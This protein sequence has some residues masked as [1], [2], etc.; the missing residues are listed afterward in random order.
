MFQ[1]KPVSN[2]GRSCI[3]CLGVLIVAAAAAGFTSLWWVVWFWDCVPNGT[4]GEDNYFSLYLEDGLCFS[5]TS[6]TEAEF[7]NSWEYMQDFEG[8]GQEGNDD[9]GNYISA[10]GLVAA[11]L[12][13][14]TAFVVAT[15]AS[16][17]FFLKQ[18]VIL[19]WFQIGTMGL[20][21]L[22]FI[23]TLGIASNTFYTDLQS[24]DVA[25]SNYYDSCDSNLTTFGPGWVA[26]LIGFFLALATLF[27][28]AFPCWKCV[29]Q[30]SALSK[31][32]NSQA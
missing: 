25:G 22:L 28:I 26:I 5:Y 8:V 6:K 7:C 3:S 17:F 30:D 15:L 32:I 10:Y 11:I 4:V 2:F 13:F 29:D 14:A 1:L 23:G 9:A 16:F 12:A 21:T 31:P 24:Y 20:V 19:R 18:S 27:F